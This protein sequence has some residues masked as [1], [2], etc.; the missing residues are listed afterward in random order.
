MIC[1][2]NCRDKSLVFHDREAI[3]FLNLMSK[4]LL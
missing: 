3:D 4:T 2:N 1:C